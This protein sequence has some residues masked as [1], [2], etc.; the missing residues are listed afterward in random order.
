MLIYSILQKIMEG[1]HIG[2]KNKHLKALYQE[3]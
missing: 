2:K 3:K 1:N